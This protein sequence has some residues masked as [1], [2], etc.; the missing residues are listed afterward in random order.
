MECGNG[1][2][3]FS[4]PTKAC[5][6]CLGMMELWMDLIGWAI[7]W[8]FTDLPSLGCQFPFWLEYRRGSCFDIFLALTVRLVDL[9]KIS[10]RPLT[11]G[12]WRL[13]I[14]LTLAGVICF[15]ESCPVLV[16]GVSVPALP[17]VWRCRSVEMFWFL[18]F[19]AFLSIHLIIHGVLS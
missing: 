18:L 19:G 17:W 4:M 14:R 6:W 5:I 1:R 12:V 8:W 7:F 3:P 10:V 13:V 16:S 15:P 2:V 11:G 9:V